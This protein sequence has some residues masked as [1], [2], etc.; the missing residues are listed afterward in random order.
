MLNESV[1]L[2][3]YSFQF[4]VSE[5]ASELL[6]QNIIVKYSKKTKKHYE[7]YINICID[8]AWHTQIQDPPLK[9][10]FD[11]SD[12]DLSSFRPYI[13]S[14]PHLDYVLWPALL[15]HEK[16][17]VV[18]KGVAQFKTQSDTRKNESTEEQQSDKNTFKPADSDWNDY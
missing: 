4:Q 2:F 17:S 1:I 8:I 15:L 11:S 9:L 13:S 16:G 14:G 5:R 12:T 7:K 3:Q 6:K 18:A 10:D